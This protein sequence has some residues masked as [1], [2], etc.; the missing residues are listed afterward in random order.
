MKAFADNL[1]E[2][3]AIL[4]LTQQ[5]LA[6]KLGIAPGTLASYLKNEKCP[7]LDKAAQ[8]AEALGTSVGVLCGEKPAEED[9]SFFKGG[10]VSYAYLI[11]AFLELIDIGIKDSFEVEASESP[12]GDH[13]FMLKSSD[14]VLYTFFHDLARVRELYEQ[15]TIDREMYD[16]WIEKR[17]RV[18]GD[19][20]LDILPF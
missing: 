2:Q 19:M 18:L 8:I 1:R 9:M 6:K 15:K 11:R 10:K 20:P 16:A 17:L 12:F 3:Q 13:E 14:S 7:T 5:K 4:G